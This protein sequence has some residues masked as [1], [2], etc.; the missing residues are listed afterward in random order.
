MRASYSARLRSRAGGDAGFGF[1]AFGREQVG[2]A[3]LVLAGAKVLDLDEAALDEGAHAVVRSTQAHPQ[4]IGQALALAKVGVGLELAQGLEG[5]V[6]VHLGVW[7][8]GVV[9]LLGIACPWPGSRLPGRDDGWEGGRDDVEGVAWSGAGLLGSWGL[10]ARYRP[11][12][13]GWGMG[14]VGLC[15]AVGVPVYVLG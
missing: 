12:L 7:A 2:V 9:G 15:V 6:F 4:G 10:R 3:E 5:E 1:D 14:W 13:S 11:A 8:A